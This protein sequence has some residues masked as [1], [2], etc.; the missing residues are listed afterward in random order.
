[1]SVV[2]PACTLYRSERYNARNGLGEGTGEIVDDAAGWLVLP[3]VDVAS[4]ALAEVVASLKSARDRLQA[5]TDARAADAATIESRVR[6]VRAWTVELR[7][8]LKELRAYSRQAARAADRAR[9]R[10]LSDDSKPGTISFVGPP[11]EPRVAGTAVDDVDEAV[12]RARE[13]LQESVSRMLFRG[14]YVATAEDAMAAVELGLRAGDETLPAL[15]EA[16]ARARHRAN[17]DVRVETDLAK[18][19]ITRQASRLRLAV[20]ARA[21]AARPGWSAV[22]WN[23]WAPPDSVQPVYLGSYAVPCGEGAG[24]RLRLDAPLPISLDLRHIGGLHVRHD[25]GTR[26]AAIAAVRG[27]VARLLAAFP[28]GKLRFTFFDPLGLGQAVSPFL[29]LTDHDPKLVD[30]KVWSSARDLKE[31]L[32]ALTAHIEVV[33]QK[34]LRGDYETIEQFNE[35]A[36]EIPEPYRVLVVLDFPNQ[37]DVETFHQITRIAE[38]GPRCGVFPIVV[39]N[40]SAPVPHGVSSSALSGP[41]P[42]LDVRRS[43]TLYADR[44][45]VGTGTFVPDTDPLE[46]G[47]EGQDVVDRV[48]DAVGRSGRDA[49]DVKVTFERTFRLFDELARSGVRADLPAAA[50][51][52]SLDDSATW[53]RGDSRASVVAPLGQSG[54]RGVAVLRFDSET[55]FGALLVGRP[56]AGKSTLLHT[57][58]A[59]LCTLYSPDELELYLI[60]FKEGVEFKA[61]AENGLPHA[62]CV[63][64][65]SERE[66]GLSILDSLVAEMRRRAALSRAT[67]G[68]RTTFASL[69]TATHDPLPR[70]VLVFDEFHVLFA[71][72]D[73]IGNAASGLLETVIRQGRGFGVHVLLGSQ[74]LSGI[75]ALGRHVPQLLPVRILLPS[76]ESDAS[77]VLGD[78]NDAWRLLTRRGEGV[79]NTAAGRSD[80]NTPF[81]GAFQQEDERLQRLRALRAHAD[82]R[83]F[84]R[85][86]VVFEGYAAA[87]LEQAS[88]ADAAASL[89]S[90]AELRVGAPL[91]LSGP[92]GIAL[93]R[94]AG[95]NVAVVARPAQDVP[96]GVVLSC[97]LSA[98]ANGYRIDLVDFSPVDDGIADL[99]EPLVQ[100][101]T[102]RL[103]GRRAAAATLTDVAAD[104]DTRVA[105]DDTTA[106]ARLLVLF[107]LHRARDFDPGSPD[108][109]A[110]E[111]TDLLDRVVADGPEVGVH[112]LV[113]CD[114]TASFQR[115]LSGSARRAFAHRVAGQMSRD[116]SVDL[117][118][119]EAAASLRTH[120]V[121]VLDDDNGSVRRATAYAPPPAPWLRAVLADMGGA[122]R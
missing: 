66:F 28:P 45:A 108:E 61:Y 90:C 17:Q 79:L 43:L 52:V 11:T 25:A 77:I 22:A 7:A 13:A 42:L 27:L 98:I 78:D 2:L 36:G 83:G 23:G 26:T 4:N 110:V 72:D 40:V 38:N 93:R 86:P 74:S 37:F 101:G 92:V 41:L 87:R 84:S 54:A 95:A 31:R 70:I 51:P 60:D 109:T 15:E 39:T 121:V 21:A 102:V 56:G 116:D 71:E 119:S 12:A 75:D 103:A 19:T 18:E 5:V 44:K 81:Q 115:R 48:V 16:L 9:A 59:G 10:A 97:L 91:A 20:D 117:I 73:K 1:M 49:D 88:P 112:T 33:I 55:S 29:G 58:V 100:R 53:W 76:S 80:A 3:A 68:E 107:G 106:P 85:R 65:E 96:T 63:A 94:E 46:S 120:Q 14:A 122:T 50:A 99:V 64:V 118:D 34:F 62:R 24:A 82:R 111:L 47:R 113:W 114:S 69:R 105:A 104:V 35:A 67:G 89:R 30:G 6:A 57:Y 32:D 8:E